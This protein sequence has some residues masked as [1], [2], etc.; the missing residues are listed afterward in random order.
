[1]LEQST[2]DRKTLSWIKGEIETSLKEIYNAPDIYAANVE[3]SS[4]ILACIG[5]LHQIK[6]AVTLV[7]IEGA[8]QLTEEL[9]FLATA[10]VENRIKRQV[11]AAEVFAR[12]LLQ[13]TGYIE[14]LYH[15]Q[16]D[17]PLVLLP[18][19]NDLRAVQDKELL[20]EGEFFAPNLSVIAPIRPIDECIVSGD[21]ST[22]AR[23]L[24]PG[25]LAGLLAVFKNENVAA[26][27][28]NLILVLDNLQQASNTDKSRQLWWVA[29]GIA[30]ALYEN[31][32]ESSVAVKLLLGRVDRQIKLV[33]D[34]GDAVFDKQSP[35]KIIKNLLY[36]VAQAQT[37]N[38]RIIQIKKAFQMDYPD[39]QVVQRARGE[40]YGF[41]ANLIESVAKQIQEELNHIK[42]AIA[43]TMHANAGSTAGLQ[44]VVGRLGAVCD[45]LN[46]L[47]K[48]KLQTLLKEYQRFLSDK[49]TKSEI[50]DEEDLMGIAA[51]LLHVESSINDVGD[52]AEGNNTSLPKAEFAKLMRLV[53]TEI[54]GDLGKIKD[55]VSIFASDTY[56]AEALNPVPELLLQIH[57][58][59]QMLQHDVQARLTKCVYDYVINALSSGAG[60]VNADDLD[61]LAD[62][63]LGLEYYYES[64]LEKSVAPEVA[65]QIATKSISELGY[66]PETSVWDLTNASKD[67][68]RQQNRVA[69]A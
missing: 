25:Y 11:E 1:M 63:I 24:R 26:G 5:P 2:I 52:P 39:E 21:I 56:H 58:V 44:P 69:R 18:H 15:G 20:T 3:D 8:R 64:I 27:L 60:G 29:S 45:A 66:A 14:S 12:G 59:M 67:V 43:L 28:E 47:G 55:A 68:Q 50:L 41:N 22:V 61:R 42:D 62:A 6:G 31:S 33:I 53:A 37:Y 36:Y 34:Y 46:M 7:G 54:V 38:S 4:P 35:D 32:L 57:G 19:L 65:L 9:E 10:L 17:I 49:I 48:T 51:A 13:I 23:K 40:L 30:D 16:P